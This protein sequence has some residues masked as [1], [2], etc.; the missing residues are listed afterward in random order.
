MKTKPK[1]KPKLY[2]QQYLGLALLIL[3]LGESSLF[4]YTHEA[5]WRQAAE[6]FDLSQSVTE[7]VSDLQTTFAPMVSAIEG[8]NDFYQQAVTAAWPLLDLSQANN[9]AIELIIAV[10]DF[11]QLASV[12]MA[13]LLDFSPAASLSGNVAGI[14]IEK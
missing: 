14:S 5:D 12:Q 6:L 8:V 11:Y 7:T 2:S 3:L 9:E 4:A 1:K 10:N 13:Q